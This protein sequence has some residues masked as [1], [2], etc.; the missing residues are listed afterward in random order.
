[1]ER[2]LMKMGLVCF[3]L[4]GA[5]L[6]HS[7]VMARIMDFFHLS[8]SFQTQ[9]PAVEYTKVFEE[10]TARISVWRRFAGDFA[11]VDECVEPYGPASA[12]RG[13]GVGAG[14]ALIHMVGIDS[15]FRETCLFQRIVV[16]NFWW[17]Q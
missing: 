9:R 16:P 3:M 5:V 2:D 11:M 6:Y 8:F 4:S 13:D 12:E 15:T 14:N 17:R 1:M 7:L 10:P